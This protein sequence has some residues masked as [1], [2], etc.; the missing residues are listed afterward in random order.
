MQQGHIEIAARDT[1]GKVSRLAAVD[2][3][4]LNAD[5]PL[6]AVRADLSSRG[7]SKLFYSVSQA[8]FDKAPPTKAESDGIEVTREYTDDKGATVT[9]APLGAELTVHLRVRTTDNRSLENVAV[10]D[11][12]PGGFEVERD[13][14]RN[15]PGRTEP[16]AD[17]GQDDDSS[18]P[19]AGAAVGGWNPD[20][21]DIREDRVVFYGDFGPE[22]REITYK[23]KVT[24]PGKFMVPAAY[25]GAM[26]DHTVFGHSVPDVF[27]VTDVK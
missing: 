13:S 17:S 9:S 23:V 10:L 4:Q 12:L 24:A 21:A 16:Q 27:E 6:D 26:Y 18:Q 2:G 22:M 14:L 1:A 25:A 8:G 5:V 19:E 7:I 20:Y 3:L 11:L 15:S